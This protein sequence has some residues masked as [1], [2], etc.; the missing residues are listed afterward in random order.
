MMVGFNLGKLS[1]KTNRLPYAVKE[2]FD[3]PVTDK[4]ILKCKKAKNHTHTTSD[5]QRWQEICAVI[6]SMEHKEEDIIRGQ[7]KCAGEYNEQQTEQ[8]TFD[9]NH[10]P[11]EQLESTW[12]NRTTDSEVELGKIWGFSLSARML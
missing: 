2:K 6:P 12:N 1:R 9:S 3:V 5:N 4:S 8:G 11:H 10:F 7:L